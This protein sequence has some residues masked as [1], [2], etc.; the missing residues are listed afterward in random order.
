M[1][2]DL[3]AHRQLELSDRRNPRDTDTVTVAQAVRT[4]RRVA[5]LTRIAP[6]VTGVEEG[7]HTQRA[8][9]ARHRQREREFDV[10]DEH[11]VTADRVVRDLVARTQRARL[12]AT[13]R[14]D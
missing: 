1:F 6:D 2:L 4:D 10:G 9:I 7:E 5:A 3:K 12:I 11:L 13:H 14:T 8:V